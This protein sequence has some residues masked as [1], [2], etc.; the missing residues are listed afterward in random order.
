MGG[1]AGR[2]AEGSEDVLCSD[3]LLFLGSR[4]VLLQ[5]RLHPRLP[6]G[7]GLRVATASLESGKVC[8]GPAV[9]GEASHLADV[10]AEVPVDPAALDADEDSQVEARPVRT[11]AAA[12][13]TLRVPR[14]AADPIQ[15]RLPI[16]PG[17]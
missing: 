10:R 8:L 4:G 16:A 2:T 15:V 7:V 12:I 9:Q 6:H 17:Q 13:C 3:E 5:P 14:Q 11:L 1:C